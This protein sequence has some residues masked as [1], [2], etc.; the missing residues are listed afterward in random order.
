[1]VNGI[2]RPYWLLLLRETDSVLVR[3]PF[4]ART[5]PRN[6]VLQFL[7]QGLR[8]F[9]SAVARLLSVLKSSSWEAGGGTGSPK[10]ALRNSAGEQEP[11]PTISTPLHHL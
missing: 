7:L 10:Q 2:R 5:P 4:S 9:S 6:A 11:K 8:R 3:P 1:M